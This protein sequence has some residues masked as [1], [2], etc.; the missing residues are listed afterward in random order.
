MA[1]ELEADRV[2]EAAKHGGCTQEQE[3]QVGVSAEAYWTMLSFVEREGRLAREG[4]D[5]PRG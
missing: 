4:A 3:A 5:A 2:Q 1:T